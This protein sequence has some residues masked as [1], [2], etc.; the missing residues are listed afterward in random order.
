MKK[1]G[2]VPH[3]NT[4][5]KR[6]KEDGKID[7]LANRVRRIGGQERSWSES[8]MEKSQEVEKDVETGQEGRI[9]RRASLFG[10]AEENAIFYAIFP[11]YSFFFAVRVSTDGLL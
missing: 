7:V 3:V 6:G 10:G 2:L 1:D 11:W 9:C 8:A 5:I 4:A